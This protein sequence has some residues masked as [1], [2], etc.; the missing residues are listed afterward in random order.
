MKKYALLIVYV[1]LTLLIVGYI[2]SNSFQTVAASSERSGRV[3]KIVE[4]IIN[5]KGTLSTEEVHK[6]VRKLAHGTEFAVLGIFL[7]LTAYEIF[8][9]RKRILISFPLLMALCTAVTDEFLQSFNDRS[10]QISDVLIDFSGAV[11]G[12][13]FVTLV[14][15]LYS[16]VRQKVYR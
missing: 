8:K 2:F 14:L 7:S 5:P 6:I 9:L 16:K 1:L 13:V 15:F 10:P 3:M 4:P 11:L 12:M